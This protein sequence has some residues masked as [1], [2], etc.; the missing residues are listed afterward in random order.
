MKHP[1]AVLTA[2]LVSAGIA[3]TAPPSE[4]SIPVTYSAPADGFLSL[5]LSNDRGQL[6][7]TLLYALPVKAGKSSVAWDG[8]DDLGRACPP[9]DYSAK[10]IFFDAP[11]SLKYRM[12]VGRSGNPPYRTADG[13]G[14]WGAN[15]GQATGIAANHDSV[16]MVFA[17]VEDGN[18]TGLQRVDFEGNIL[19][20]YFSFYPWDQRS[21]AA[22]DDRQI[23]VAIYASDKLEVAAYKI[24]EPR[25]KILAA[26]PVKPT[27]T[28]H[29][30]WRNRPVAYTEG[31][32]LSG[33]T[34]YVSVPHDNAL[35][36]VSRTDGKVTK[37]DLPTPRGLAFR[38]GKLFVV[39]DKKLL[40]LAPDGTVE[41]TIIDGGGLKNP[42]SLAVDAQGNFYIGDSGADSYR[43][44][45]LAGGTREADAGTRQIHVFSPDGKPLRRI[46]VAGG[47]PL[48][49][50]FDPD[51][52]GDIS[53]IAVDPA[54]RVWVNDV[55]TG[56]KRNSVWSPE[57]KLLKQWFTRKIQHTS[58][59]VNPAN[60]R[61]LLSI[62]DIFDDSPPGIY[63]YEVDFKTGTWK[64]SWFYELTIERSYDPASGAYLSFE[65]GGFPLEE[66]YPEKKGRWPSFSYSDNLAAIN[67]RLYMMQGS[68]N[69]EGAIYLVTP[70]APPKPVA[71]IGY[72]HLAEKNAEGNWLANYDQTG[73]NRWMT[74]ADRNGDG[75]MQPGEIAVTEDNPKLAP[76]R[77]VS[78]GTLQPD[79][80]VSLSM[81]GRSNARLAPRKWLSNGA[82]VFDWSD[83]EILP[84]DEIP[85]FQ[86]GDGIKTPGD[87]SVHGSITKQGTRYA[88]I[89]PSA[90]SGLRLPGI[91]GEGW[92]ASRNWRKKLAAWN[93]NGTLKWAVGRRAPGRAQPGQM[94]NPTHLSGVARD[95]LFV[96]DALAMTW[97]WH[98]EGFYIGRLF[99][100]TGESVMDDQGIYVEM[101][102]N[103]IHEADG[104]LYTLVNDTGCAVHEVTVPV[105]TPISAGRIRLSKEDAAR[106]KPWDPD[107]VSPTEKPSI[108][109][110][111]APA[112]NTPGTHSVKV[113]GELDGREG[114]GGVNGDRNQPLLVLLDG[115]SLATVNVMYDA[116]H[117][118]LGYRVHHPAG[119]ANSGSELPYSPFVSGA[120][121][122]FSI[123]PDWSTP[124]RR[125]VREGDVRVVLARVS[126][127]AAAESDFQQG[128]W[129]KRK[130]GTNAQTIAS[131]AAKIH[132]DQIS[133]V[134][135]LRVAYKVNPRKDEKTGD[136]SYTVEVAVPL[137]S[138]G[139]KDVAG[140]TLGFDVSVGTANA[141]GDT[142]ERA[143]H[144]AG[145]SEGRVVDRPGSAELL[146]HTWGSI[147]F[148]QAAK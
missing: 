50:R 60:P 122:D 43:E 29:G 69:G 101:M 125:E 7:R 55:A 20:R 65:H 91:D 97:V 44:G 104:R 134:P 12:T 81:I 137:L 113:D 127:G 54:G 117:L 132:F 108:T 57:G 32:A 120:Y 34:V 129:Q 22:M 59:V 111:P 25:G 77:R 35:C 47:S 23:Y 72:H 147:T 145:L 102:G 31:M 146:P 39:S 140:K 105:F 33:T 68:G 21:S 131:P 128:F 106:A 6:V 5:A 89:E 70:D 37:I 138:L 38:D 93:T 45:T 18:I 99:H 79:G 61:E 80:S 103:G 36:L 123:A 98:K 130:G 114:W 64:P 76:F 124:Q 52:F 118:Y 75:R 109:A 17:C 84:T 78:S 26:L 24:D 94:Y 10:G 119:A 116:E 62:R 1:L 148:A 71:M 2:L 15:L 142:R 92:W 135:G 46:G 90:P 83:L 86:G 66:A 11:P 143:A 115:Q 41:A 9:G 67:G 126:N 19:R 28:L 58:D 144:W 82:P 16:M 74:W 13:K 85:D 87:V 49:G 63:A 100:D 14:D 112:A 121:V 56:F 133:T 73:P 88:L 96:S 107:G 8:T 53:G 141:A 40:R 51:G 27:A 42:S 48:E 110:S 95:C 4:V 136:I 139:L 30:R 3:Q